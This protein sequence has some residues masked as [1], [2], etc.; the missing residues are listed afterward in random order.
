MMRNLL[1]LSAVVVMGI[2][3]TGE[4]SVYTVGNSAGWDISADFPSWVSNNTFYVG[5]V[6][7]T[8]FFLS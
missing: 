3:L 7:G 1:L 6:L 5:D 4:A 8:Y 2:V